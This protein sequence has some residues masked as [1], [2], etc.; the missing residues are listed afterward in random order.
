MIEKKF[1]DTGRSKFG[2]SRFQTFAQ[3]PRKYAYDY[4]SKEKIIYP[5][6]KSLEKGSMVHIGLA[7]YYQ[8]SDEYL[9]PIDAIN[10][11]SELINGFVD[12]IKECTDKSIQAI[13]K[14]IEYYKDDDIEVLHVIFYISLYLYI[15]HTSI[16]S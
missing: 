1:L 6:R 5:F 9:S 11:Y 13:E 3:C 7:H 10:Y 16:F 2:F 4:I 15:L 8:D 12:E 14:Y